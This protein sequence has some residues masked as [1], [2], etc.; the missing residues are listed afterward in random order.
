MRSMQ[1][2]ISGR[3]WRRLTR[4]LLIV[5]LAALLLLA[6]LCTLIALQGRHDDLR[7]PGV[8]RVGAAIVL[9]A[10]LAGDAP[11]PNLRARLDHALDLYRR[12][13]VRRII[14]T[15]GRTP[16]ASVSEAAAGRRYLLD[17]GLAAEALLLEEASTS[18]WQNLQNSRS[19][20]LAN[21]LGAVVLVSDATHMLRALKMARDLGLTAYG[22]PVPPGAGS[23]AQQAGAAAGEALKYLVYLFARR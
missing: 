16:G 21:D 11:P 10:A 15:G 9:G 8:A 20:V 12:G 22:S 13:Q 7:Q 19:L 17:R 4:R 6:L 18:T 14:L 2:L 3:A 5:A 23:L 1:T